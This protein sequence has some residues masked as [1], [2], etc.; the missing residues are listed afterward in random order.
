MSTTGKS[1]L[2]ERFSRIVLERIELGVLEGNGEFPMDI[3]LS[4]PLGLADLDPFCS[5]VIGAEEA[6][7]FDDGFEEH[8]GIKVI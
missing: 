7:V 8:R 2:G 3:F 1:Q 4:H 5:L 6:F